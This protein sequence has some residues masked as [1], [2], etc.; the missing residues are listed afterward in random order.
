[1][2]NDTTRKWK[3]S[4]PALLA[5]LEEA[6]LWVGLEHGRAAT[7]KKL[8]IEYYD[9]RH[10]NAHFLAHFQAMEILGVYDGWVKEAE[11][12]PGLK[13]RISFVLKKGTILPEGESFNSNRPRNDGFVYMLAGKLFHG[14]KVPILSVDGF[15][16]TRLIA[17]HPGESFTSDIVF[18]HN[19][20]AI[21][22]ECKRP[23]S[24]TTLSD[25]VDSAFTQI[26]N[27]NSLGII[28]VDVSKLIEQPGQILEASTLDDGSCSLTNEIEEIITPLAFQFPQPSLIGMFGYACLP[29]VSTAQSMILN[30]HGKPFEFENFRTIAACWVAIR[31]KNSPKGQ[32]IYELQRDF[33]RST[34]DVPASAISI[35]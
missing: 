31:N 22:I 18:L 8:L 33:E 30:S 21:R 1:M 34:H 32:L 3:H 25:N 7:Y 20:D 14:P 6:L 16:N 29:L 19:E 11:F 2:N 27:A 10:S 5:R 17:S 23:M 9:G 15:R 35:R 4:V 26:K 28:A 24:N 12:F 13:E